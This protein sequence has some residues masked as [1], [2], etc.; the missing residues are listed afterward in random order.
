MIIEQAERGNRNVAAHALELFMDLFRLFM[1][2]LRILNKLDE[3][4]KKKKN[5]R[6]Y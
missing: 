4:K 3:N 6:P 5:W 1:E 2:I